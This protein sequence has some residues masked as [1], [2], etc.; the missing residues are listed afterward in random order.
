MVMSSVNVTCLMSE[1]CWKVDQIVIE[2]RWR[3]NSTFYNSCLNLSA[4]R[5]LLPKLIFDTPGLHIIEEPAT[6]CCLYVG[7]V[8]AIEQLLMVRIVECS[9]Q[10]EQSLMVHIVERSCQMERD[11]YCSVS[12][13]F[14]RE[15]GRNV[16]GH[17]RLCSACMFRLKAMLSIVEMDVW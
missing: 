8:D 6:D 12:R 2:E 9:C 16:G 5:F 10:N 14:S 15:A 3:H 4:F 1:A 13:L 17:R 7:V 11:E